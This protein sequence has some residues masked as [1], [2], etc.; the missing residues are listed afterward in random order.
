MFHSL[1]ATGLS[2]CLHAIPSQADWSGR[3][4]VDPS[5]QSRPFG[6]PIPRHRAPADANILTADARSL[7]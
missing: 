1:L 5:Q 4:H 3:K 6:W 7:P 2:N